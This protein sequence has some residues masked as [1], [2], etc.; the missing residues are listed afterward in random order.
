MATAHLLDELSTR[1][2]VLLCG[3]SK[4]D[5]DSLGAC[6]ALQVLL[7]RRGV[8]CSVAGHASYRYQWMPNIDR[9]I[10]DPE[11]SGHW[12]AVVVLDGDRHRLS[13][14]TTAAFDRAEYKCIIDHHQSTTNDGYDFYWVDPE[15]GSA[16]EMIYSMLP[17]WRAPLDRPL[18]ELLYTGLI[19]DTGAFRYSNTSPHSFRM[20]A[21]LLEHGA[22]PNQI[23]LAVL[24]D[25]TLSGLRIAGT[26]YEHASIQLDGKL[27]SAIASTQLQQSLHTVDGDLEGV[28]EDLL[29]VHG[30]EVSILAI[31]LNS[32]TVKLSLRSRGL[33]DVAAVANRLSPAGGGHFKAAGVHLEATPEEAIEA[34]AAEVLRALRQS[35]IR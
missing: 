1:E 12:P 21:D 16:C 23:A 31:Q 9:L 3:P 20:A 10:P 4:P 2:R 13:P 33:I 34:A 18:S 32:T 27:C 19:F 11:L 7:E 15:A 26:I 22:Q 6:L 29:H 17:T 24:M 28:V 30:V 14:N 5:G 35:S 8:R 25:R